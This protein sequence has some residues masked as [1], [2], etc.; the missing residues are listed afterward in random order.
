[1]NAERL[2][3]LVTLM[4]CVV[5]FLLY[6]FIGVYFFYGIAHPFTSERI[7]D[8]IVG[9]IFLT[10]HLACA[11]VQVIFFRR[12][13]NHEDHGEAQYLILPEAINLDCVLFLFAYWVY[14]GV[15]GSCDFVSR[16]SSQLCA[17]SLYGITA[18]SSL[19]LLVLKCVR[20]YE[21]FQRHNADI[22][23]Y[24]PPPPPLPPGFHPLMPSESHEHIPATSVAG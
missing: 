7:N 19:L 6:P 8:L 21:A 14:L 9:L 5:Y 23:G 1:M 13:L 17:W 3:R 16:S 24:A 12:A 22:S 10:F 18:I 2:I 20:G 11:S 15:T 4:S